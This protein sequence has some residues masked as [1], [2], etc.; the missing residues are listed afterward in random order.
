[1]LTSVLDAKIT[2][3]VVR[4]GSRTSD[5]RIE[6]LSLYNLEKLQGRGELDRPMRREYATMK[7]V[8]EEMTRIM[9]RIQLPGLTWADAEKFLDFQYP[10]HADSLRGPPFWIAELFRRNK[11]DEL[12]HGEWQRVPDKGKKN[13]SRDAEIAGVYGLWKSGRDIEFIQPR[14][15]ASS[16]KKGKK[17]ANTANTD[18]GVVAFFNELGFG[19]LIPPVPSGSR[20]LEQLTGVGNV[21]SMSLSE[22]ERLGEAWEDDMRKLNYESL[23]AEFDQQRQQ[24]KDACKVYEDMQDEVSR[25]SHLCCQL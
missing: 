4:L 3:N 8:E 13:A 21:W 5:E 20:S 2:T 22:R 10:Q 24:Y 12:E 7:G 17:G 18:P 11:E 15:L 14:P 25:F 1:M 23:L 6:K 9:N 19:G 16:S